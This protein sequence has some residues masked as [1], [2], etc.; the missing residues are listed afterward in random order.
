VACFQAEEVLPMVLRGAL[1]AVAEKAG[2]GAEGAGR[3]AED[4]RGALRVVA[5]KA[6]RGTERLFCREDS[7]QAPLAVLT[8]LFRL[9]ILVSDRISARGLVHEGESRRGG[10]AEANQR[11]AATVRERNTA[12]EKM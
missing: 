5:E 3:D 11:D 10:R 1:G 8:A 12:R 7:A 6:G 2:R 4:L 9:R